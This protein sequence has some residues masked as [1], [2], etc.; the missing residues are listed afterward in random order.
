M[1]STNWTVWY[2]RWNS[3]GSTPVIITGVE[4]R[5]FQRQCHKVFK[6]LKTHNTVQPSILNFG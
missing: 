3:R 2:Q 4:P 1:Y 6:S 5:L